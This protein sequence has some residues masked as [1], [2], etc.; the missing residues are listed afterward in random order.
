M[1]RRCGAPIRLQIYKS[2]RLLELYWDTLGITGSGSLALD[3][4][5]QP[6]G[7]VSATIKGYD[8]LM[9]AFSVAGLLPADEL[10]PAKIALAMLGPAISTHFTVQNGDMYLGPANLGKAPRITWK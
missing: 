1:Q 7:S 10:T 3:A 4:D 8:Q 6:T 9:M 2:R 5:L